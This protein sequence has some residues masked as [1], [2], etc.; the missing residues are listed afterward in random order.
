MSLKDDSSSFSEDEKPQYAPA[1]VEA[2]HNWSY[3]GDPERPLE[4]Y[5]EHR[6]HKSRFRWFWKVSQFIDSFG[7]ARTVERLSSNRRVPLNFWSFVRLSG[8]WWGAT[9]S[10]PSMTGFFLG[11]LLFGLSFKSSASSGVLGC[12]AG[13]LVAAFGATMGP[14]SGLRQM[15]N[16]R[17]QFGWWFSKFLAL[18]NCLTLMGWL[19]VNG[20]FGGQLLSALSNGSVSTESGYGILFAVMLVITLFGMRILQ[21]FDTFFIIPLF[22]AF[23]LC[24]VCAAR[25][26]D[27]QHVSTVSGVELNTAWVSFFQNCIGITSTWMAVA[28]DY[29]LEWPERTNRW[30]VFVYVLFAVFIPT[31]FVGVLGCGI[32]S[33]ALYDEAKMAVYNNLGGAGLIVEEMRRWHGGGKFLVALM[34]ISLITNGGVTLYSFGMSIQTLALPLAR[35][36][37]YLYAILG[38]VIWFVLTSVGSDH[39]SEV[40]S[41]FL[42]MI[43]YWSMIYFAV[44]A[45]E[46]LWFRRRAKDDYEWDQYLNRKHFPMLYAAVLAFGFG[47]AGVVIGM[48][49]YYYVGRL[50]RVVGGGCE[51]GTLLAFGFTAVSYVP[52]RYIEIRLRNQPKIKP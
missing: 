40:L 10:L 44:V 35:F 49:Q 8:I 21:Y 13:A 12:F 46:T 51:L 31:A 11:P 29:H 27:V 19:M 30:V 52:L 39:W 6:L 9:C 22:V 23:L 26:F 14:Q 38:S 42:P 37:R 25:D 18:L 50:A 20:F 15:M 47:V 2:I 34:Y 17:F 43:G 33:A 45:I 41:N 48:D 16:A 28:S 24:Y 4:V 3:S 7:E 36:P 1:V 5:T 32:A